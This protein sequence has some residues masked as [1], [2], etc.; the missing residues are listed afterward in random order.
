MSQWIPLYCNVFTTNH[1]NLRRN[2]MQTGSVVLR[3]F[4]CP[5]F[6]KNLINGLWDTNEQRNRQNPLDLISVIT[7][8]L[9]PNG[10]M[11]NFHRF[12][13]NVIETGQEN[14][15]TD[16]LMKEQIKKWKLNDSMEE[17]LFKKDRIDVARIYF[18]RGRKH[19]RTW[20]F[21]WGCS[22]VTSHVSGE[23]E[24]RKVFFLLVLSAVLKMFWRP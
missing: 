12:W 5:S 6:V 2:W 8:M 11:H 3:R 17:V 22:A 14:R 24:R 19:E 13:Q 1:Y 20:T 18:R 10:E 23:S 9:E 4:T 7:E 15:W 21:L 16:E